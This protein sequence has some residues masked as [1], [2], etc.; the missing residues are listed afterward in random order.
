MDKINIHCVGNAHLDPAWMW[1]LHE[2]LEAFLATCRSAIERIK[3]NSDFI[4]TC[5]SAAHYAWVEQT[6]PTLFDEIKKYVASGNWHITGGWWV[7]ADCNL[8]TGESFVRQ[9][10]L[11]QNYFFEKFGMTAKVGYSPDAFGHSLGLVQLLYKS[12]MKGY[13]FCRPEPHEIR[14]P[15]PYFI[16]QNNQHRVLAYRIPLHYNMYETT[17]EKKISDIHSILKSE[18]ILFNKDIKN[19]L[20]EKLENNIC[21]F[22]GVGNHGG[23]PTKQHISHLAGISELENH[24]VIF[25]T[26]E[27][28]INNLNLL[29][30]EEYLPTHNDDIQ[31]NAPGCYSLHSTIKKLNRVAEY[32]LINA[33]K[34]SVLSFWLQNKIPQTT[35]FH[36]AWQDICF[37]HFHDIICGVAVEP[38]MQDATAMYGRAIAIANDEHRIYSQQ[39][40]NLIDTTYK[41]SGSE[42]FENENNI[43][44]TLIVFNPHSFAADEVIKFELWHDISK[45]LWEQPINISVFDDAG[46]LITHQLT[47][48]EGK[49]GKDRIAACFLASVPPLGVRCY[50]VIYHKQNFDKPKIKNSSLYEIDLQTLYKKHNLPNYSIEILDDKSDSWGHGEIK[51][52]KVIG[53]MSLVEEQ[54][55]EH[56]DIFTKVRRTFVYAASQ[57]TQE[58]IFYKNRA[59]IKINSRLLFAEP[60]KILRLKF[61]VDF[62]FESSINEAQYN[63]ITKPNDGTERPMGLFCGAIKDEEENLFI[64]NDCKYSFSCDKNNLYVTILRSSLYAYHMPH[65][66]AV[67]E[68]LNYI[69]IGEQTFCLELLRNKNLSEIYQRAYLLNENLFAKFESMHNGSTDLR[70]FQGIEIDKK[71]VILSTLKISYDC[72]G[73]VLRLFETENVVTECNIN[74]RM[75]GIKFK[76][77]MRQNEV[78]TFKIVGKNVQEVLL[79]EFEIEETY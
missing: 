64:I 60:N 3:E 5:S 78:K 21:I 11:A 52:D 48:T 20:L 27:K 53:E 28:F 23:G 40:S 51:F 8:P 74:L 65:K 33:E 46:N 47:T 10:L 44:N 34:Y 36:A 31:L 75:L 37:N 76:A 63:A 43:F 4:F 77:V 15:A 6:D 16:W 18:N 67:S 12:G 38:A 55:I 79:T 45:Q 68:P 25:S 17:I 24:N 39:I 32:K 57:L 7:Q 70:N 69:D 29:K 41:F 42:I 61:P 58:I 71:N 26:P 19:E 49:I 66:Y 50:N 59:E 62:D 73:F 9:A 35:S 56:E 1:Q 30:A 2:G 22:Y 72:S 13:V 54:I 14:L